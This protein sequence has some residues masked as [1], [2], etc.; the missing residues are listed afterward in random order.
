MHNIYYLLSLMR[1]A[2]GAILEDR[3]PDF[4]LNYFKRLYKDASNYPSWAVT[5]LRSV[6]VDLLASSID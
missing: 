1:A 4:L 3:Y 5:A 2:R 6:G